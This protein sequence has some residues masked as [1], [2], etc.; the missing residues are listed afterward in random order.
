MV[1]F[2]PVESSQSYDLGM[3]SSII[4][5]KIW[6]S[7]VLR[8][9][10]SEHTLKRASIYFSEHEGDPMGVVLEDFHGLFKEVRKALLGEAQSLI[11]ILDAHLLSLESMHHL[12]KWFCLH[13]SVVKRVVMIG[14]DDVLSMD[15]GGGQAFLDLIQWSDPA[16]VNTGLFHHDHYHEEM[17]RM[18]D[19]YSSM[20][21]CEEGLLQDSIK[22]Q[23]SPRRPVVKLCVLMSEKEAASKFKKPSLNKVKD[24]ITLKF[25]SVFNI[26]IIPITVAGLVGLDQTTNY[27]GEW[28]LFIIPLTYLKQ[29][30]RNEVNHLLLETHN[31]TVITEKTKKY[32][33][34]KGNGWFKKAIKTQTYPN[35][36]YTLPYAR[37]L[38]S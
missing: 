7:L 25:I 30:S 15:R 13:G 37:R 11:V 29:L 17:M 19:S 4:R 2:T 27:E 6:D 1:R 14:V 21:L 22:I 3:V 26:R 35:I 28:V 10:G 9:D 16:S 8:P 23:A 18:V 5:D 34:K 31:L 36:R 38:T 20:F 12:L 24:S 33:S 32:D